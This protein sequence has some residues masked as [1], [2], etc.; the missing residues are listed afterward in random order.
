MKNKLLLRYFCLAFAVFVMV[1]IFVF[2]SQNSTVSGNTSGQFITYF[3]N[4]FVKG[5][6]NGTEEFKN[7][8]ILKA[9][10]FVR[11]TAHLAIYSALAFFVFGF[12]STVLTKKMNVF[13]SSVAFTALYAVSDEIHQLFVSGRS[14]ELRD[15]IIDVFGAFIGAAFMLL[16][17][18]LF[19]RKS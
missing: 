14:G 8:I 12:I 17:L 13:V 9:D 4:I 5:F 18:H 1:L 3:A 7:A 16:I 6:K 10:F 19:R 15:L 11:K 2:S